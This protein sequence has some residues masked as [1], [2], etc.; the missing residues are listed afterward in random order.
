MVSEVVWSASVQLD[1]ILKSVVFTFSKS[2]IKVL[3]LKEVIQHA[4]NQTDGLRLAVISGGNVVL[5]CKS[6]QLN[7]SN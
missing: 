4:L 5:L 1:S 3:L 7:I 6:W 2:V